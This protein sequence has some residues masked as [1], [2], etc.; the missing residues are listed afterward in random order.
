MGLCESILPHMTRPSIV[1]HCHGCR[2]MSHDMSHAV[3]HHQWCHWCSASQSYYPVKGHVN[4]N[5]PRS[6]TDT[7]QMDHTKPKCRT[8]SDLSQ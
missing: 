6:L 3:R 7:R 8:M 5:A 4:R 2:D 1:W